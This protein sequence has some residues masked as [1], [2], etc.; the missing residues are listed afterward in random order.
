MQVHKLASVQ[1]S[2]DTIQLFVELDAKDVHLVATI[3]HS[4][5]GIANV[6]RDYKV[7]NGKT[8][9]KILVPPDF[10]DETKRVLESLKPYMHI[11]E[12]YEEY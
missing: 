2:K 7:H 3:M 5:D 4:Y 11:G 1:V 8:F 9:F 12:M 6:R 10:L